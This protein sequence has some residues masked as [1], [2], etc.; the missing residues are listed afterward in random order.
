MDTSQKKIPL[1]EKLWTYSADPEGD[2]RLIGSRCLDCGEIYFPLRTEGFCTNCQS[3]NFEEIQL[4]PH[5]KIY[6]FTTVMQRPPVYYRGAVPYAIGYVELPEGVRVET[7]FSINN[8]EQLRI[9]LEVE[10]V[11]EKLHDDEEGNEVLTYKF[12]PLAR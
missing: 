10:L 5:G 7:L 3:D 4:S 8:L 9:G 12:K 6:S 11:I 1:R 2:P